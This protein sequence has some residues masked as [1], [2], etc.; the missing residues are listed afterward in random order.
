MPDN[1]LAARLRASTA[2][3][4][5]QSAPTE[6]KKTSNA[7]L[8][9]KLRNATKMSSEA[10][11]KPTLDIEQKPIE[12]VKFKAKQNGIKPEDDL[13][14]KN[15][16]VTR[17][18]LSEIAQKSVEKKPEKELAYDDPAIMGSYIFD[19]K[20]RDP[21]KAEL[22]EKVIAEKD[23]LGNLS[24]NNMKFSGKNTKS[25]TDIANYKYGNILKEAQMHHF[26]KKM[27]KLVG[28]N[29]TLSP[30][31]SEFENVSAALNSII[32]KVQSVKSENGVFLP[33]TENEKQL[34]E[35]YKKLVAKYDALA[36]D[37]QL[38]EHDAEQVKLLGEAKMLEGMMGDKTLETNLG[39]F[40][41]WGLNTLRTID[42]QNASFGEWLKLQARQGIVEDIAR[43]TGYKEGEAQGMGSTKYQ[44][45]IWVRN[46]KGELVQK[47]FT[48]KDREKQASDD[49]LDTWMFQFGNHLTTVNDAESASRMI[50]RMSTKK[51]GVGDREFWEQDVASA[52]GSFLGLSLPMIAST[53]IAAGS[54]GTLVPELGAG[55]IAVLSSMPVGFGSRAFEG[56]MEA[57]GFYKQE[58]QKLKGQI[59]PDT[60]ETYTEGEIHQKLYDA[61]KGIYNKNMALGIMDAAQLALGFMPLGRMIKAGKYGDIIRKY[62]GYSKIALTSAT[63]GIEAMTESAEEDIQGLWQY[64]A[65]KVLSGEM[66]ADHGAF[67]GYEDWSKTDEAAISKQLG[68]VGG[69]MFGGT[70]TAVGDMVDFQKEMAEKRESIRNLGQTVTGSS[71]DKLDGEQRSMLN[72]T[73][74][75]F[76]EMGSSEEL[77]EGLKRVREEMRPTMSD[78]ANA[79]E[80]KKFGEYFDFIEKAK[81]KWEGFKGLKISTYNKKK[82]MNYTMQKERIEAEMDANLEQLTAQGLHQDIIDAELAEHKKAITDIDKLIGETAKTAKQQKEAVDVLRA[83]EANQEFG[84]PTGHIDLRTEEDIAKQKAKREQTEEEVKIE[85]ENVKR[86]ETLEKYH[87]AHGYEEDVDDVLN[88]LPSDIEETVGEIIDGKETRADVIA[89]VK[90]LLQ[91]AHKTLTEQR[92]NPKRMNT[93]KLYDKGI[94]HIEAMSKSMGQ[95]LGKKEAVAETKPAEKKKEKPAT[96]TETKPV[97]KAAKKRA[98]AKEEKKGKSPEEI[99]ADKAK[100]K[101]ETA[102]RKKEEAEKAEKETKAKAEHEAKRADIL[103]RI[104]LK[105]K[106]TEVRSKFQQRKEALVDAIM[107]G[108]VD[109]RSYGINDYHETVVEEKVE[110]SKANEN[111]NSQNTDIDNLRKAKTKPEIDN[112][113]LKATQTDNMKDALDAAENIIGKAMYKATYYSNPSVFAE[114]LAN[115]IEK[116]TNKKGEKKV[117]PAKEKPE[118]VVEV[119]SKKKKTGAQ[120]KK[121]RKEVARKAE[122]EKAKK[123]ENEKIVK[124]VTGKTPVVKEAVETKKPVVKKTVLNAEQKALLE[125]EKELG[126]FSAKKHNAGEE[127]LT[128]EQEEEKIRAEIKAAKEELDKLNAS[129]DAADTNLG[130]IP[131]NPG[132]DIANKAIILEKIIAGYF[133]LGKLAIE[134][135]LDEIY[136]TVK[137]LKEYKDF[138][139]LYLDAISKF[140]DKTSIPTVYNEWRKQ[141]ERND[142]ELTKI[143]RKV[144]EPLEIEYYANNPD[145]AGRELK[146]ERVRKVSED[147]KDVMLFEL[148]EKHGPETL[149]GYINTMEAKITE[150][151]YAIPWNEAMKE[152]KAFVEDLKISQ[153]EQDAALESYY[154]EVTRIINKLLNGDVTSK[155]LQDAGLSV[156]DANYLTEK[157]DQ[158]IYDS[159]K[160]QIWMSKIKHLWNPKNENGDVVGIKGDDGQVISEDTVYKTILDY[161][162]IH[163]NQ[164]VTN[165]KDF[166][167]RM[168]NPIGNHL[169]KH[170]EEKLINLANNFRSTRRYVY[171]HLNDKA[172]N[173]SG[174]NNNRLGLLKSNSKKVDRAMAVQIEKSALEYYE[175]NKEKTEQFNKEYEKAFGSSGLLKAGNKLLPNTRYDVTNLEIKYAG[176]IYKPG[177]NFTTNSKDLTFSQNGLVFRSNDLSWFSLQE[178]AMDIKKEIANKRR[179]LRNYQKV[180]H[181]DLEN[182][183][184]KTQ[185]DMLKLID[186]G[187]RIIKA[188][189][190][191]EAKFLKVATGVDFGVWF[192]SVDLTE[193]SNQSIGTMY[194]DSTMKHASK[195][196]SSPLWHY[197]ISDAESNIKGKSFA[198]LKG[199]MFDT[200]G[201]RTRTQFYSAIERLGK[202]EKAQE[203]HMWYNTEN[204]MSNSDSFISAIELDS[205]LVMEEH[206][207]AAYKDNKWIT[208]FSK[209]L[210]KWAKFEGHKSSVNNDAASVDNQYPGD[211][212]IAALEAFVNETG[213]TETKKG[214]EGFYYQLF[215]N[216]SDKTIKLMVES[217]KFE[218]EYAKKLIEENKIA[219]SL[220]YK[221]DKISSAFDKF[222]NDQVRKDIDF[223][224]EE[225]RNFKSNFKQDED[226]NR[227]TEINFQISD[228]EAYV[229]NFI[230][231]KHFH[232]EYFQPEFSLDGQENY[233]TYALKVK[234]SLE[235][236]GV[237]LDKAIMGKTM[238]MV[239][240]N[241]PINKKKLK[242]SDGGYFIRDK[243]GDIIERASGH[244]AKFN[245]SIKAT[246]SKHDGRKSRTN[247]KGHAVVLSKEMSEMNPTLSKIYE[248]MDAHN[249]D[250]LAFP[251]TIKQYDETKRVDVKWQ[252]TS[253]DEKAD[254]GNPHADGKVITLDTDYFL[255]QQDLRQDAEFEQGKITRQ[256]FYFDQR[257]DEFRDIQ[258]TL[259][260]IV[261]KRRREFME[262]F[263]LKS[264]AAQI[265]FLLSI[266]P[267]NSSKYDDFRYYFSHPLATIHNEYF[268]PLVQS[269]ISG[270]IEK[271]VLQIRAS[272]QIAIEFPLIGGYV[273]SKGVHV[274]ELKSPRLE[275]GKI[276][277]GEALVPHK[278]REFVKEG[279]LLLVTRVPSSELHSTTPVR[280]MGFL[281]E[282]MGN[283]IITD[284]LTREIAGS[285]YDGD[286]RH[287]WAKSKN[288]KGEVIENGEKGAV[289]SIHQ[290]VLDIYLG[291]NLNKEERE[292]R[293]K[294]ITEPINTDANQ[295]MLEQHKKRMDRGVSRYSI[296]TYIKQIENTMDG[297]KTIG[298]NARF[299]AAYSLLQRHDASLLEPIILPSFNQDENGKMTTDKTNTILENFNIT[300]NANTIPEGREDLLG[301]INEGAIANA[302]RVLANFLN[303]STDNVKLGNLE[304]MGIN[305]FT[306]PIAYLLVSLGMEESQVYNYMHHPVMK[307][308][309]NKKRAMESPYNN[310]PAS[311]LWTELQMEFNGNMMPDNGFTDETYWAQLNGKLNVG[312]IVS[313]TVDAKI[314]FLKTIKY[315][316]G[317]SSAI[318]D[319]G[320]IEKLSYEPIVSLKEK[321][322][323]DDKFGNLT[324][325]TKGKLKYHAGNLPYSNSLQNAKIGQTA[326]YNFAKKYFPVFSTTGSRVIE[327]FY[328]EE[329]SERGKKSNDNIEIVEKSIKKI[330]LL[331]AFNITETKE[332]L[333]KKAKRVYDDFTKGSP[334][335]ELFKWDDKNNRLKVKDQYAFGNLSKED[336][337]VFALELG[338]FIDIGGFNHIL[339]KHLIMEYGWGF[340]PTTG[341]YSSFM[342]RETHLYVG[343]KMK[344]EFDRW[345]NPASLH[346][347]INN[348]LDIQH[349]IQLANPKLIPTI[350]LKK[351]EVRDIRGKV[352]NTDKKE[353]S[354]YVKNEKG[355]RIFRIEDVIEGVYDNYIPLDKEKPHIL[356]PI[357]AFKDPF[358]HSAITGQVSGLQAESADRIMSPSQTLEANT[359]DTVTEFDLIASGK[360]KS[361]SK[362]RWLN[363]QNGKFRELGQMVGQQM[364]FK[365]T[366][367]G[368]TVTVIIESASK[369]TA[370]QLKDSKYLKEYSEAERWTVSYIKQNFKPGMHRVTYKLVSEPII[371]EVKRTGYKTLTPAELA[372][373]KERIATIQKNGEFI[374]L[375]HEGNESW[376]ENQNDKRRDAKGKPLK[377]ER[378]TQFTKGKFTEN[379]ATRTAAAL[380]TK[381]D[382]FVRDFFNNKLEPYANY[383]LADDLVMGQFHE[384]LKSLSEYLASLPMPQ[385][386]LAN[387]IMVYSEADLVAGELD[388]LTY[389]EAGN[390]FIYDMKTM[391]GNHFK[392]TY[393]KYPDVAKYDVEYNGAQSNR[394]S[395][396]KQVSLQRI[397]LNNTNGLLANAVGIMPIQLEYSVGDKQTQSITVRKTEPL[398]A[399][400]EIKSMDG[401]KTIKLDPA[402]TTNLTEQRAEETIFPYEEE[403]ETAE[404]GDKQ[405]R[406]LKKSF[407][408]KIIYVSPGLQNEELIKGHAGIKH[409]DDI[410]VDKYNLLIGK[411]IANRGNLRELLFKAN[412]EFGKADPAFGNITNADLH[413]YI[414]AIKEAQGLAKREGWLIMMQS[415]DW[416]IKENMKTDQP[417]PFSFAVDKAFISFNDEFMLKNTDFN[418][419]SL[420]EFREGK[421]NE[422]GRLKEHAKA[423]ED[424]KVLE[425]INTKGKNTVVEIHENST[426][427]DEI[428]Q[429]AKKDN[430][431]PEENVS[432]PKDFN[433]QVEANKIKCKTKNKK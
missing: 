81:V 259:N 397:L 11:G 375:K 289:N 87:K 279:E 212:L 222:L 102:K 396:T 22:Y 168:N 421:T 291:K 138:K 341:E 160:Q 243:R 406:P 32:A 184:E 392:D 223:V 408:G 228:A 405:F 218:V 84:L 338:A 2:A 45:E 301:Q 128:K 413:I 171:F 103:S 431:K 278:Y 270:H 136:T 361:T 172:Q 34:I 231:N 308:Y 191:H 299:N 182:P 58:S 321:I 219:E 39:G 355:T 95:P 155:E 119:K 349:Q 109:G 25:Q 327:N 366:T 275:N 167:Q 185:E 234:R 33:Q 141:V 54:M 67:E 3:K 147:E 369:V 49:T 422:M 94:K 306:A 430:S 390:V 44:S 416:M 108:Q 130:I 239:V 331:T 66:K 424:G 161:L 126:R 251:S 10:E 86:D 199:R 380:G 149:L 121:G 88:G 158:I 157:F 190:T 283:I 82:L 274:S 92:E 5:Q 200:T 188:I 40:N 152:G 112:A 28:A 417:K 213:L 360:K 156:E 187:R 365:N 325:K 339:L 342:N 98:K 242:L 233:G 137:E 225:I 388:L 329:L 181:V 288:R 118:P 43:S 123:A 9:E 267:K 264:E 271:Q 330:F 56:G 53:A 4:Q 132:I 189:V 373:F 236:R 140:D 395:H 268:Q 371:T 209:R 194:S 427:A 105:Q 42:E 183:K 351:G 257:F 374:K 258:A 414:E 116:I 89:A 376:Y 362:L 125:I 253:L 7:E 352:L 237:Q 120:K 145:I 17:N 65:E 142:L 420:R 134:S 252:H 272:K 273:N 215:E 154:K 340:A 378:I 146:G 255:I 432:S 202:K 74:I 377:Y 63:I 150:Q 368:K 254:L 287:V 208:H 307:A 386:V 197:S 133:K 297:S 419:K 316:E 344:E 313:D 282:S 411:N 127:K 216:Q 423:G 96:V 205:E 401:K 179:I 73:A 214:K 363:V 230:I 286:V 177:Q 311:S 295:S 262:D 370:E 387:N 294:E 101:E 358:N 52:T 164:E 364:T 162:F 305:R 309:A 317:I 322:S 357:E 113:I 27:L 385:K 57:G 175:R 425:M 314:A 72:R 6:N 47:E 428:L 111:T 192:E 277:P 315:L 115:A 77:V 104:K 15:P 110:T 348:A 106:G 79:A 332:D 85:E 407:K 381:V 298:I 193:L 61:T 335:Y 238:N 240:W 383:E 163:R 29:K 337:E 129:I 186:K 13:S 247:L 90:D 226:G 281:P 404:E 211:L 260:N 139:N 303:H 36:D 51:L 91:V 382:Q 107:S 246:Y 249:I 131:R 433:E 367:T 334:L 165:W 235:T 224:K 59:N 50:Q 48:K 99:K 284:D 204:K 415:K 402:K 244:Y 241:D 68:F 389:D 148:E 372:E 398:I 12:P 379:D 170:T 343:R 60:G 83:E 356:Q 144:K 300:Y 1:D 345:S 217:K 250:I 310:K 100:K 21:K 280:V 336:K 400:D 326:F 394:T 292:Q 14:G 429:P 323:F 391:N 114:E 245:Q 55:W 201:K 333:A 143:I 318:N 93:R 412:S 23:Y 31:I 384:K 266:V 354:G 410:L 312:N 159:D 328:G 169:S 207:Q 153:E 75:D 124:K 269:L 248:Y 16:N 64:Q 78:V 8:I 180:H 97:T 227:I 30:K 346:Y 229:L 24:P 285:D 393:A 46:D 37:P 71:I 232:D 296:K 347:R 320:A 220:G 302:R 206:V 80:D 69:L 196:V 35:S 319:L 151:N 359:K 19:L 38:K 117:I 26:D 276:H 403:K 166:F 173:K 353:Y 174:N 18:V 221:N 261:E 350:T 62:P 198:A 122:E 203:A 399:M 195:P 304:Y 76:V 324:S 20:K 409:F 210:P 41:R 293:F 426:L 263:V 418:E 265:D 290:K 178:R 256:Q 70:M 176:K 135:K